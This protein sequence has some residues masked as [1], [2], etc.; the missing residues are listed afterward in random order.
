M[1]QNWWTWYQTLLFLKSELV[2]EK[3]S[4]QNYSK[5]KCALLELVNW[6][7]L[8]DILKLNFKNKGE[9][10]AKWYCNWTLKFPEMLFDFFLLLVSIHFS[11]SVN[12]PKIELLFREKLSGLYW[13]LYNI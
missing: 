2:V 10:T 6:T 8:N 11:F 9:K 1:V 12:I 4:V 13:W 5:L 7:V 3:F